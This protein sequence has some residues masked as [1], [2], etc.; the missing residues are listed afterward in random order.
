LRGEI[1]FIL[2]PAKNSRLELTIF[3]LLILL[4]LH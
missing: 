3:D 2:S 4:K 1:Q